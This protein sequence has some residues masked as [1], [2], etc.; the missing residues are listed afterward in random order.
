M[1]TDGFVFRAQLARAAAVVAAV[2]A[3]LLNAP[4][5]EA[6][7][8]FLSDARGAD[9]TTAPWTCDRGP[10]PDACYKYPGERLAGDS[11]GLGCCTDNRVTVTTDI[12][13]PVELRTNGGLT[14][15]NVAATGTLR[16]TGSVAINNGASLTIDPFGAQL[17]LSNDVTIG[18]DLVGSPAIHNSGNV[19][20]ISGIGTTTVAVP[21]HNNGGQVTICD[22][23]GAGGSIVFT[24]GGS[25]MG[26]AWNSTIGFID[27]NGGKN[28]F[29][30]SATFTSSSGA[31]RLLNGGIMGLDTGATAT[32]GG[33][34]HIDNSTLDGPGSL[35]VNGVLDWNSGRIQ[36]SGG[37]TISRGGLLKLVSGN[38]PTNFSGVLDNQGT[39]DYS[40]GGF[41][42]TLEAGAVIKN[43]GLFM[44][45][46][47]G[48]LTG[49]PS[50]E[51]HNTGTYRKVSTSGVHHHIHPQFHNTGGV[52]EAVS[53][54]GGFAFVGGGT[55]SGTF[56]LPPGSVLE[57]QDLSDIFVMND[58]TN[59]TSGIGL[60]RLPAGLGGNLDVAGI[61]TIPE[62]ELAYGNLTGAGSLNVSSMTWTGGN[63]TGPGV[64]TVG[65]LTIDGTDL[66]NLANRELNLAGSAVWR[67]GDIGGVSGKVNVLSAARL[68]IA[69]NPVSVTPPFNNA[70]IVNVSG[71]FT[72]AG[73]GIH[74]G[75]FKC[76][77]GTELRFAGGD[78]SFGA[79]ST[80]DALGNVAVQSGSVLVSGMYSTS[81]QT[82][83]EAAGAASFIGP[84]ASSSTF[85]VFG[86][87]YGTGELVGK[88]N[89]GGVLRP[90][91]SPGA[92]KISGDYEQT[93][94]G[95]LEI[96]LAGTTPGTQHDQLNVTGTAILGG[97]LNVLRPS[98]YVPND[99]DRFV[100]LTFRASSGDFFTKNGLGMIDNRRLVEESTATS[101]VLVALAPQA[102]LTLTKT[103]VKDPVPVGEDIQYSLAVANGGPDTANNVILTDTLPPGT[104]FVSAIASQGSCGETRPGVVECPLGT[105]RAGE[106]ASVALFVKP[107][108][109]GTYTNKASVNATEADPKTIDN[110]D[111]ADTT[112][113]AAADLAITKTDSPDPVQVG[114]D[115]TYTLTAKN[116]GPSD[117]TSVVVTDNLPAGVTL[118]SAGA[119]QGPCTLTNPV[120]CSLGTLG[121]GATATVK[122]V[123]QPQAAGMIRNSATV[124][125]SE[126]D[127]NTFDNAAT[128]DTAVGSAA[129][130]AISKTDSPDPILV[131]EP[132]TYTI[133]VK[134]SGPSSAGSVTVVDTIPAGTT[135]ESA[136]ASQGSC[137]GSSTVTCDLGTLQPEESATVTIVVRPTV[138]GTIAN[139]ATVS[140]TVGDPN[141]ANNSAAAT[142]VVNSPVAR[143][144][145]QIFKTVSASRII[146][147]ESVTYEIV[148]TNLGPD[149]ANDVMVKDTLPGGAALQ[150][151]TSD[152]GSCVGATLIECRLGRM[153]AKDRA[154]I[155]IRATLT[156]SG[157]LRNEAAVEASEPDP[158]RENNIAHADVQFG[159]VEVSVRKT[160]PD[161]ARPG[162]S[163]SYSIVVTNNSSGMVMGIVVRDELPFELL[164]GTWTCTAS[165]G[166]SCRAASG[167]GSINT[168]V[169]LPPG[170][171]AT[172]AVHGQL[173]LS[174]R[175]R[176]INT[177]IVAPPAGIQDSNPANNSSRTEAAVEIN[178]CK[179]D[180]R[181]VIG[182]TAEVMSGILFPVEAN[183]PIEGLISDY[184]FQLS[185]DRNDF[186]GAETMTVPYQV[187]TIAARFVRSVA[188]DRRKFYARGR[189]LGCH[190]DLFSEI[191]EIVVLPEA[192]TVMSDP[193]FRAPRGTDDPIKGTLG[194]SAFG[195]GSPGSAGE[196]APL[197]S[198]NVT[199]S[200]DKAHLSVNPSSTTIPPNG[201]ANVTVTANPTGLPVGTTTGTV[202]VTNTST[203]ATSTV[204]V[205]VT[206]T[207]PLSPVAKGP[208]PP[209]AL[210]VPVVAHAQGV[211]S[212]WISDLRLT[213]TAPVPIRYQLT[214]TPSEHDGTQHGKQATLTVNP[215]QTVAF[216]NVAEQ[217]FGIGSLGESGSGVLEIRPLDFAGK[218]IGPNQSSK[219]LL[220]TVAAS[221]TYNQAATGTVSQFIPG[222][223]FGRAVRR[224]EPNRRSV[225]SVQHITQS[226][227]ART[228]VGFVEGAG[229]AATVLLRIFN[230]TG[231]KLDEFSI[232]LQPAEHKQLN[233]LLAARKIELAE[234][235]IEMEVTSPT[236][237]ILG[238]ASVIHAGSNDSMFVPGVDLSAATSSK[239]IVPAVTESLAGSSTDLWI[240]NASPEAV[241]ATLAFYRENESTV[242]KSAN[243]T[244]AAGEVKVLDGVLSSTFGEN[245]AHGTIQVTTAQPVPL[246]ISAR[247]HFSS[248]AGLTSQFLEARTIN[249]SAGSAD[250][251]LQIIQLEES[252]RFQSDIG[253]AE[254]TGNAVT[255]E[256]S[257]TTADSKT[258][259]KQTIQLQPNELRQIG[260]ILKELGVGRVYNG[261]VA[262]KVIGG[263]GRVLA[264]GTLRDI[265][266]GD[267]TLIPAQ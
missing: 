90:G 194:L 101:K 30:G 74:S 34:L 179:E 17:E 226:A 240:F 42:F 231:Q 178:P 66:K 67:N 70:G 39:V 156:G 53:G 94:G 51:I 197:Q 128:A 95:T 213:N 237:Q 25:H 177:A 136:S 186:S 40:G 35:L 36:G 100:Y 169:N 6:A 172:L 257:G 80:I 1:N 27:F 144:D 81:R 140:S 209:N 154:T 228:N 14:S 11:A 263:S 233:A 215:G 61:I 56:T 189:V 148:V 232:D 176:L 63:M 106:R 202:V 254:V 120:S 68:D 165:P 48:I 180:F 229:Q 43:S 235:R 185:T 73:G 18:S 190:P 2:A 161:S 45:S 127:P 183:N 143:A 204:P 91:A 163:V 151:V 265:K 141:T 54:A 28:V 84:Q 145:L 256:I 239:F 111:S 92:L 187:G 170:G 259:T 236:G 242:A 37:R 214:L 19:V 159:N 258:E 193:Q 198:T 124:M 114:V 69:G 208:S 175:Q 219:A 117:A 31:V 210:I 109:A 96:E 206:L 253:V 8:Y 87:L 16:L 164:S 150:D 174:A 168:T 23:C 49:S 47:R 103:D 191:V 20:K 107:A 205:S 71:V 266:T 78:Y 182:A 222:I 4:R 203:G 62:L 201:T 83:I 152:R 59:F 13:N 160:G 125:A 158:D 166:G 147:G 227:E 79:T 133:T 93:A 224:P 225:L 77:L 211:S 24:Q 216:D 196:R 10:S 251:A 181:L 38:N 116:A 264:Y 246:I 250:R 26:G 247:S 29:G 241:Q 267:T 200:T 50:G 248:A 12:P 97:T 33:T 123:V 217:Q 207:T 221:R 142:T 86:Q 255:V 113:A 44:V 75:T 102:D 118:V 105:L 146:S 15:V 212:R 249:D 7:S 41:G 89:N 119:S 162:D 260:S 245:N 184:Q 230:L 22:G 58:G 3:L 121:S 173:S 115:L 220:A 195:L 108:S 218:A 99:G 192:N 157:V 238:Y 64:T 126:S 130:L 129:D 252:D 76:A 149:A 243:V 139:T 110:S 85:D 244:I 223:P 88:V 46:D 52:M 60:M 167:S 135:F 171:T 55:S 9:W 5:I 234:G 72:M 131:G 57:I 122:I 65:T 104:T 188:P 261:R 82:R 134:N 199:V 137:S 98:G 153:A 262:V 32:V 132:L 21:F 138:A 112:V 155:R